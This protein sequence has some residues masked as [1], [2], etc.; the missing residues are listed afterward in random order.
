M[1]KINQEDYYHSYLGEFGDN[2]TIIDEFRDII[3]TLNYFDGNLSIIKDS[4]K[5]S[6]DFDYERKF[7]L[8]NIVE[9]AMDD[10][11]G[12]LI[13]NEILQ[14]QQPFWNF[15]N[16]QMIEFHNKKTEIS[17]LKFYYENFVDPMKNGLL[18]FARKI[19]LAHYLII[20]LKNATTLYFNIQLHNTH[21]A[22]ILTHGIAQ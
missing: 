6:F 5:K 12:L 21:V 1:N 10:A 20:Q 11:A 17:D 8:K 19:P 9:K 14:T 13:N 22:Q 3:S 2:Q 7:S 15:I 16:T 4:L 18:E